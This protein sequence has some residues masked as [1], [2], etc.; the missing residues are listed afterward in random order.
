MIT[1]QRRITFTVLVA[2]IALLVLVSAREFTAYAQEIDFGGGFSTGSVAPMVDKSPTG[3]IELRGVVEAMT[4]Q[5]WIISGQA[6]IIQPATEIKGALTIGDKVKVH[7][8]RTQNGSLVAREIELSPTTPDDIG[9]ANGNEAGD[10]NSNAQF[11][12]NQNTTSSLNEND[13]DNG[14]TN[15][16]AN[17]NGND[18][19][20]NANDNDDDSNTN[21]DSGDD[22]GGKSGKG[23]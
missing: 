7:V 8:I 15:D 21:D 3:E 4:V 10:D 18:D 11:G 19:N 14:N 17:F 23:G 22:H 1:K 2:A 13:D 9:N 6:V 12:N 20:S 16:N 5:A